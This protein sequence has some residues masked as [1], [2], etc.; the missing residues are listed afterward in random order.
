MK[1]IALAL[2]ASAAVLP[3][4]ASDYTDRLSAIPC[5]AHMALMDNAGAMNADERRAME[6]LYSYMPFP[7]IAC[8]DA[9]FYLENVRASL[10]ARREMPWG[11]LVPEREFMHFVLPVR[12]NNE[13]LDSSRMVF[14][15]ELR[16]RVKN[17]SMKDAI[18]EVNHW[19]HEKVAYQPSD[20]RT[21]SPLATVRTALGRCGEESTFTVAALRSVGIPARQ[22]YTPRWAHTDDN[23]A[24]VEA[25][26]D[27]R[28]YFLGACEPEP[29]LDLGWFNAP[30]SRGMLMNTKVFGR[31]DGPE[32]VLERQPTATVINVTSKYAP[33]EPAVVKVV[34]KSGRSVEGARVAFGVYNYA[35]YFSAAVKTSGADGISSLTS[36]L[37]DLMV[38]ASKGNEYGFAKVNAAAADTAVIVLDKAPGFCGS[39]DFDIVP[40]PQS[41]SLP[42]PT[43]AQTAENDRRKQYEDSVR[44]AYEATFATEASAAALA[45]RIGAAPARVEAVL[46]GSRGNHAVIENFLADKDVADKTLALDMLQ[47]MSA[48]DLRDVSARVLYDHYSYGAPEQSQFYTRYVLNPRVENEMLTPYK[49]FLRQA[50][51]N[52]R[53]AT[54]QQLV[55]WVSDSIA[56]DNVWNPLKLRMSPQA[57][58]EQRMADPLSRSIFFVAAARTAGFPSRIDPVTGKTQYAS[59]EN[60]GWTDVQFG[61]VAEAVAPPAGVADI[62]YHKSGR[63]DQPAYYSHFSISKIES[64]YPRLL[65]FPEFA[66]ISE[67]AP[68]G[69]LT[70]DAGDYLLTTGQRLASGAVL[71]RSQFFT[72]TP[73]DTVRV[74]MS[75]RQ[76]TTAVQVLG[77]FNSENL[78]HNLADGTDRSLLSTTGRG[79]YVLGLIKPN[80]EPSAHVLNDIA[81]RREEFESR[82][83]KVMMLFGDK[84]EAS[85][86]DA[87]KFPALPSNI[88]F[89]C[90]ID[91]N[92]SREL[93]DA[94]DVPV[95]NLPLFIIA[96]T[97]NRVVFISQGYTIGLGDT[98]LDIF[99]R[100]E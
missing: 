21:S 65:E 28:W 32:E 94:L 5:H 63:I 64:G 99:R 30:A 100:I 20:A 60:S 55:Q 7:D 97:F 24:W 69:L 85:R 22:V 81:T 57:V 91:G 37:G 47:A 80:H 89:G 51:G 11:K 16:D 14:Y 92:I 36:G 73:G 25:W 90:D 56:V 18:L 43:A 45:K 54:P 49:H 42:R 76:D 78:Y 6:F 86:F 88:V 84:A 40:P 3:L 15:E 29:I 39:F 95:D 71:A 31:Y 10:K 52:G 4:N 68:G 83:M 59:D 23:H 13:D 62:R 66:P 53:F 41:A 26:A 33:V 58:Y 98:I 1:H 50:F 79:Y 2:L 9:R 12:V 35:E 87:G 38:W 48:K 46:I 61:P 70:L 19:C 27:G 74:D 93:S 96:D 34:D 67:I 75:I 82:G 8:H 44:G 77:S 17:L 72:V